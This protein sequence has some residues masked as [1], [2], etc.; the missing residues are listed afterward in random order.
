MATEQPINVQ[1]QVPSIS[2]IANETLA[3][4]KQSQSFNET[5]KTYEDYKKAMIKLYNEL[6]RTMRIKSTLGK[7]KMD[8]F[9]KKFE[10]EIVAGDLPN[11]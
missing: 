5:V 1:L 4:E 2:Q 11:Y 8:E 10:K 6:P 9:S 7:N 3:I